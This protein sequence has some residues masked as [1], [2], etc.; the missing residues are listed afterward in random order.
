MKFKRLVIDFAIFSL[1]FL[2]LS[3]YS[4][5]KVKTGIDVLYEDDFDILNGKKVALLTNITGVTGDGVTTAE[6]FS[7]S[8]SFRLVSIFTPEHGFYAKTQAGLKVN[9]STVFGVKS[10][11][12]YGT[13]RKPSREQ[14][15]E[16][17]VVIVDI[18]DIGI[19]SYTYFSTVFNVMSVCAKYRIPVIILDR[20]NPINGLIIDGNVLDLKFK[21]FIGIVPVAYLHGCTI[22]ELATMANEQGW[23]DVNDN[24]EPE[25]CSLTVIKMQGWERWMR[26][27]DT[28]LQWVAT[29]PNIPSPDAVRGAAVLGALGE[30]SF[31]S[32][33]IGTNKP[34]QYF[35][36]H[37]LNCVKLLHLAQ[38]DNHPGIGFEKSTYPKQNGT[39]NL[40]VLSL[41]FFDDSL[42][43]PYTSGIKLM[44]AARKVFHNI[45][46]RHGFEDN[47]RIMF[48]KATGTDK[49]YNAFLKR[50]TDGYILKIATKGI[51]SYKKIRSKYLLY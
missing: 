19:R 45:F 12:L 20:P 48:N 26:W 51:D 41:S 27:E 16:S 36:K 8:S 13:N 22:G 28:G 35:G 6:L 17:D 23:L 32:I 3:F 18:Q 38:R 33:G 11:S 1:L 4:I 34:F 2:Y 39:N 5:S 9:D 37:G 44:L 46:P 50:A 49:I 25:K 29:S 15:T 43:Q 30:L 10:W 7:K 47:K 14:V 24:G 31:A 40:Q 21:S 42:F